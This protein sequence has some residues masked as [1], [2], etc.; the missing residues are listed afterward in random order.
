MK[1]LLW[2]ALFLPFA[3]GAQKIRTQVD[4]LTGDT[5]LF[6]RFVYL[7]T[8]NSLSEETFAFSFQ[9]EGARTCCACRCT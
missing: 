5:T 7:G 3:A 9:K 4:K 6:T 1:H 2:W 8:S